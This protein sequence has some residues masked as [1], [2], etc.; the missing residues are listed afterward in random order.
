M[1]R[2]ND[3]RIEVE[4]SALQGNQERHLL[5]EARAAGYAASYI[6]NGWAIGIPG[7]NASQAT[8]I[9]NALLDLGIHSS[10]GIGTA[11]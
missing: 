4:L 8:I 7:L 6:R 2:N 3:Y 10:I 1:N 9:R 11:A 5:Q